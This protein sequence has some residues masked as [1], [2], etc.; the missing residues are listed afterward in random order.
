M[1][2]AN[3]IITT[4]L[5]LLAIPSPCGLTDEVVHYVG[6][7][8][9]EIGVDYEMTRRGTIRA[10]LPGLSGGPARA[11]V[12]HVDTIGAMV[13]YIRED[14][15]LMVAPI[16]HWSSRFA[17]GARVTLFSE[18]RSFRGC[19]LPTVDWGV[20]RDQGVNQV[21]LDWD[22]IE[23]RLEEAVFN[24]DQVRQLGIEIG[25]FI[26]L[27]SNPEV[28]ENG[29][30][31]GRNLDNKAGIASV[32]ELLRHLVESE[33]PVTHDTYVIFTVNETTGGGM[34]S[35]ILPEV[36]ELLTVDFE[37]VKPTEKSPFKRVTLASGDASGPYDYHLT[38]HLHRL[39]VEG[40]IPL[41]QKYLRAFHSDAAAAL[42]AGHDVRTAVIAYAG[43]ASHS[44]ERTHIESLT[45]VVRMLE[46]YTTSEPTFPADAELTSVERFSRQIDAR[47]LPRH[48]VETP[49]PATV[50]APPAENDEA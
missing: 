23:L 28:L 44:V 31:I 47:T 5:D 43:D 12:T 45:N 34:G 38:Q 19:L 4:L 49:D 10:R 3:R 24:D 20:S 48:R 26:A 32:L 1:I 9:V 14:G 27:E 29:Y 42:V 30:I 18:S 22:H 2:D 41:Q 46:A 25:D 7:V 13:R 39:A 33:I 21:P 17:E 50:I 36:S 15:R 35:A 11:V 40:N 16:G 8:L 37:S 6:K